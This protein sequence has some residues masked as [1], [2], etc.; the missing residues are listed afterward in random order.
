LFAFFSLL[1]VLSLLW[2]G[3]VQNHAYLFV[4]VLWLAG[5]AVMVVRETLVSRRLSGGLLAYV[6]I[7]TIM[8]LIDPKFAIAFLAAGWGWF[9]TQ[10]FPLKSLSLMRFLIVVGVLEALLALIQY[11][12]APGWIFGYQNSFSV[13]SGTLINRNHFAGL[14]EMIVPAT[15]GFA[16]AAIMR[17]RDT[18]R[19]YFFL[20]LGAFITIA[21][22][23]SSSRMGLF[24]CLMTLLFLG[25][26][27]RLKSIHKSST[28]LTLV[29][30]GLVVAGALWI[31]VD[32]IVQRFASLG[33]QDALLQEGRLIVYS[34]TLKLIAAKPLGIG[35]QNYRDVFRQYQTWHPELLMDHAHNDYLEV[36]AD[37]GILFAVV[38]WG[39]VFAIFVRAF[40]SFLRT[41]SVE[42]TTI[43][44]ASMGAIFSLLLHSLTDFNLQIPS[45]AMLFFMF[46]GIAAQASSS[47]PFPHVDET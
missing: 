25:A 7:S 29:V 11:F 43:L 9:A 20:L 45:N 15:V 34:D 23:F 22:V 41:Q 38:F 42:R 27:L 31:G 2:F 6:T 5:L 33:D 18:A 12:V 16:F 32:V 28:P 37:W 8:V 3:A 13:S 44:L 21:I 46:V 19:G 36:A 14:L 35:P 39:L 26:M 30:L 1:F 24:S 4:E 40:R 17:G 47:V 10:K